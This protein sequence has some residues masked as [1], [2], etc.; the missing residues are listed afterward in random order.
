MR[1]LFRALA[2]VA[3]PVG[4]ASFYN[5]YA[6]EPALE[7]KAHAVACGSRGARCGARMSRQA[8][9]PWKRAYV[10]TGADGRVQVDCTRAFVFFGEHTCARA[11]TVSY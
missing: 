1:W 10:Y 3:I 2:L 8:R 6:D 11:A 9:M 7:T 5:V 4:I